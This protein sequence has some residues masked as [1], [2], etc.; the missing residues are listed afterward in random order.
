MQSI[1]RRAWLG[2]AILAVVGSGLRAPLVRA[3]EVANLGDQLRSV[4]KARRD[5]EFA[6]IAQVT[7]L[8]ASG[9]LPYDMVIA[10]MKYAAK[11]RPH[12]PF[13]WFEQGI[14]IRA[15]ELGV[16]I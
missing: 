15:A 16:S 10:V 14:R 6:F 7:L 8:V 12:T 2:G 4:L 13:P 5:I 1:S 3:D 9:D 11:K